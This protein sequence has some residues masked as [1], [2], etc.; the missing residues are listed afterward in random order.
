MDIVSYLL[1]KNASGGGD[2]LNWSA[3]GL[4][5]PPKSLQNAYNYSL[6]IK[7]NWVPATFLKEKFRNDYNLI[8]APLIDTSIATN[9]N[10]FFQSCY[11]LIKIPLLDTSNVTNI[12]AF[13]SGCYGL[14]EI[15]ILD[16]SKATIIGNMF[17]NC[18]SLTDE[19]LDNIL[20]MCI[21]ANAYTGTKELK[22]IGITS[23][24]YSATR[25]QALP[26]YQDF[27][28]AG[29]TIGY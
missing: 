18:P 22:Q 17:N 20:Q 5:N 2:G 23:V 14:K 1:G 26:H 21:E 9:M 16:I 3:L 10:G 25:I 13:C 11:S 8:F 28:N 15:P 12:G 6:D 29:W 27:I 7:N 4:E 19:S 24:Y